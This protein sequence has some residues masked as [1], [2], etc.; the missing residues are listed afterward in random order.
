M[1]RAARAALQ[2][3]DL[4]CF[5]VEAHC[6][7]GPGDNHIAASLQETS[8]PVFLV[9]NK[10]DLAAPEQLQSNRL[11]YRDLYHLCG[12][13]NTLGAAREGLEPLLIAILPP[14][15]PKG[16]ATIPRNRLPPPE[17]F[18]SA[19]IIRGRIIHLTREEIPHAIAWLLRDLAPGRPELLDLRRHIFVERAIPGGIVI[20][21]GG[22]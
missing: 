2:E 1:I 13:L 9:L 3:S 16:R 21:K 7:P 20:G 5:I 22:S 18:I 15:S 8:G 11:L 12:L 4:A 17:R 10:A 19:E 6:R 14:V